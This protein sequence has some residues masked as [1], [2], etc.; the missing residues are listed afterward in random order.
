MTAPMEGL[1]SMLDDVSEAHRVEDSDPPTLPRG[2]AAS[3]PTLPP[4]PDHLPVAAAAS[5]AV[6]ANESPGAAAAAARP[7]NEAGRPTPR[8]PHAQPQAQSQAPR[9]SA[10]AEPAGHYEIDSPSRNPSY[11]E[12]QATMPVV[13]VVPKPGT[14]IALIALWSLA[15]GAAIT[16]VV[17]LLLK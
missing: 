10:S 9:R 6:A 17:L 4:T 5:M 16:A 11:R 8:Q 3:L 12:H 2:R 15:I 7:A 13:P 14:R 1:P